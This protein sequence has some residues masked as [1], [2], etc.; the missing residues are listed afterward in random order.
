MA[1]GSRRWHSEFLSSRRCILLG[2]RRGFFRRKLFVTNK[3]TR[4]ASGKNLRSLLRGKTSP[5][6]ALPS[7]PPKCNQ[8]LSHD[9]SYIAI[10]F[11]GLEFEDR[12][13]G[14]MS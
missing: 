9:S 2:Q 1:F 4:R 11:T 12:C 6:Q 5:E 13:L 14:S 8:R 7:T 3:L 10:V